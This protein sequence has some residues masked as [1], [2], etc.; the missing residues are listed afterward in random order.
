MQLYMLIYYSLSALHVSGNV[1]AHHQE[2]LTLFKVSGCIHPSWCRLVSWMSWNCVSLS[3]RPLPDNSQHPQQA[4]IYDPGGIRTHNLSRQAAADLRLRPRG[5]W[6][7]H[8][9]FYTKI[10]LRN[11]A[12]RWFL[13]KEYITMHGPMNVKMIHIISWQLVCKAKA[14]VETCSSFE[15]FNVI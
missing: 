4:N 2:H 3:Q 10:N 14:S 5:H 15:S 1:F 9:E 11:S 13:L 8:I 12:S 7:R 6:D